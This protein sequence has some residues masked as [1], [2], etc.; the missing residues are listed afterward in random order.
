MV[1][2]RLLHKFPK[3]LIVVYTFLEAIGLSMAYIE[4]QNFLFSV[5]NSNPPNYGNRDVL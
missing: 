1:G 5:E 4:T 3:N 2:V